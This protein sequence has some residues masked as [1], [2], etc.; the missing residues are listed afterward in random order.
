MFSCVVGTTLN[1]LPPSQ[2]WHALPYLV[3]M[4]FSTGWRC[5]S[6]LLILPG[7]ASPLQASLE[8]EETGFV[9]FPRSWG[10]PSGL[11][12]SF[13]C[14]GPHF[15]SFFLVPSFP[16]SHLPNPREPLL[17]PSLDSCLPARKHPGPG[18]RLYVPA[19]LYHL[20]TL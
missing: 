19:S 7:A 13:L 17:F 12:L 3:S 4:G 14:L 10:M 18:E 5:Q 16:A 11:P 2:C 15:C 8:S 1:F 20:F 6:S 9:S